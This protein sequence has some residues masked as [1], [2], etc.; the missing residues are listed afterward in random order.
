MQYARVKAVII[1]NYRGLSP[2]VKSDSVRRS[3]CN[4]VKI[5]LWLVK[6]SRSVES[7]IDMLGTANS[8]EDGSS[9]EKRHSILCINF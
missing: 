2:V 8:T 1:T 4:C 3:L 7:D 9:A 5:V 6:K